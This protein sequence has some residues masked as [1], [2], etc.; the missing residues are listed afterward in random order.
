MEKSI[1]NQTCNTFPFAT[2][3]LCIRR[4]EENIQRNLPKNATDTKRN[5][6]MTAIFGNDSK[7]DFLIVNRL[8]NLKPRYN[9]VTLFYH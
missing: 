2:L 8:K 4:I 7:K 3:L 1:L 6:V 9:N 5:E